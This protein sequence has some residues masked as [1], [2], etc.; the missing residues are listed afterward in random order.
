ML[1][2]SDVEVTNIPTGNPLAP[3]DGTVFK[4]DLSTA[5]YKMIGG[6]KRMF[7]AASYKKARYPKAII[8]PQAEVDQYQ[9]GDDIM[10]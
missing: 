5:I 10:L 7:T 3:I 8:L 6:S 1:T 4:G 2:L 9:P